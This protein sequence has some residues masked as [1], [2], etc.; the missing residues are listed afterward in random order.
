MAIHEL[1]ETLLADRLP[2]KVR[3]FLGGKLLG[4]GIVKPSFL[5]SELTLDFV[6]GKARV[7]PARAALDPGEYEYLLPAQTVRMLW[8][9]KRSRAAQTADRSRGWKSRC[10][11]ECLLE[12]YPP[13]GKL[14]QDKPQKAIESEVG[15]AWRKR[16]PDDPVPSFRHIERVANSL[17]D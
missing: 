1:T 13:N 14:P 11:K 3:H 15:I 10:L 12:C 8:P 4:E 2:M 6:E 7:R 9:A 17:P 5:R 16:R